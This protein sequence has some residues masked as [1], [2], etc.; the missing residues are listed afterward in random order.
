MLITFLITHDRSQFNVEPLLHNF[1]KSQVFADPEAVIKISENTFALH[2][3]K[4]FDILCSELFIPFVC[5]RW[6]VRQNSNIGYRIRQTGMA[7]RQGLRGLL[8][9]IQALV[10]KNRCLSLKLKNL[11]LLNISAAHMHALTQG[12][13]SSKD[14]V[15][16]LEDDGILSD[17]AGLTKVLNWIESNLD[18][19]QLTLVDLSD[20]YTFSELGVE[21]RNLTEILDLPEHLQKVVQTSRPITNTCA[22][23]IYS[24]AAT[25]AVKEFVSHAMENRLTRSVPI[26]WQLNRFIMANS[27]NYA[28]QTFH[29]APGLIKQGSFN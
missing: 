16:I 4:F 12:V 17:V 27:T 19:S 3:V 6:F 25:I 1:A 7:T 28:L 22:A 5:L 11:R 18:P 29:V 23:I 24:R 14:F 9:V 21:S 20:S 13:Y 15:C 26:D 10:S 2:Q 8:S